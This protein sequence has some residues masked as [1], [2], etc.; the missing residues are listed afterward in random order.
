MNMLEFVGTAAVTVWLQSNEP[1]HL[2][3][4]WFRFCGPGRVVPLS[5]THP[6]VS[7]LLEQPEAFKEHFTSR[8]CFDL[9]RLH[10][11]DEN[12]WVKSAQFTEKLRQILISLS[13]NRFCH[14]YFYCHLNISGIDSS[15]HNV[16]EK[17]K[18]VSQF[19]FNSCKRFD[20]DV[21]LCYC[22]WH[23]TDI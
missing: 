15:Y 20:Q 22:W 14:V 13:T 5:V 4:A 21:S 6:S 19:S 18:A 16:T 7:P 1:S 9:L 23:I 2:P 8:F 17:L 12:V 3:A 10:S 11:G